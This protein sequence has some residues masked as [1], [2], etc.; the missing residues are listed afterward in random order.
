ML[1]KISSTLHS[2]VFLQYGELICNVNMYYFIMR[3]TFLC[4]T[5]I[6][7]GSAIIC[8]RMKSLV[9]AMQYIN[10]HWFCTTFQ[11]LYLTI[12]LL[13]EAVLFVNVTRLFLYILFNIKTVLVNLIVLEWN[14]V[15]LTIPFL[16]FP[17]TLQKKICIYSQFIFRRDIVK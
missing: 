14:L 1:H 15:L 16:I 5:I 9:K 7:S 12:F 6:T 4:K 10:F 17:K 2:M 11:F 3:S 13:W 8:I